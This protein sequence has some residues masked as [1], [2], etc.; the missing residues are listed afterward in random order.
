MLT[1]AAELQLGNLLYKSHA[2]GLRLRRGLLPIV[3]R[4]EVRLPDGVRLDAQTGDD[5]ILK[6]D[7]G[8]GAKPV[9]TGKLSAIAHAASGPRVTAH[10]G[11][12]ALARY[13]P[14]LTLEQV[15]VGDVISKLCADA[16]VD[17][18]EV[19]SGPTLSLYVADGRATALDEIPRLARH[20]GA[21]V[22]F[23][24]DGHLHAFASD[25]SGPAGELALKWGRELVALEVERF[26]DDGASRT[27][28]GDGAGGPGSS[29]ARWPV[30]DFFD[31][32]AEA[33]GP[34]ARRRAEPELR[35]VDDARAAATAWSAR[36]A[37]RARPVRLRAW[38]LP[39]LAPGAHV[40]LQEV[41]DSIALSSLRVSQVVHVIDPS[42]GAFTEAW[43][44]EDA[45]GAGGAAGLV[46]AVAGL[47]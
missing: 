8:E 26:A 36:E 24:G 6:L 25:G 27:V 13:R 21:D 39:G 10:H 20:A 15:A 12:F 37:A 2:V 35:T 38:L 3:D 9:F 5:A 28:V 47:L 46:A 19:A 17:T 11:A 30:V 40:Q 33:P 45:G 14:S 23:D 7:G 42:R 43:G 4:L 31:G 29:L 22:V 41:P 34:H 32:G 18:G 44:H 16:D 1:V